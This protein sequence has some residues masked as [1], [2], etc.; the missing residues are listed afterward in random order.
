M[1]EGKYK[2][3]IVESPAKAQTIEKYLGSG[4]KVVASKGHIQDLPKKSFGVDLETFECEIVTID[5]KAETIKGIQNLAKDASEIFLASDPDREG[6]AIA[7]H[8]RNVIKRKDAHRVLFNAI[9]K[10][11]I[12]K[13]IQNPLKLDDKKYEAQQTRRILD[14]IVGYKI[15]PILWKKLQGG[16]SAGRVQS[17]ALRLVVEREEEIVNF[18][19]EKTYTLIAYL[20]KDGKVFE[21][22]YYGDNLKKKT[23]L[24]D[25]V[26]AK[27]ILE[28]IKNKEFKV[29]D[30][31]KKEKK[32][33]P[34]APFTTSKL[35][36]E[37]AYKLGFNS[38][39]TM[40][41][42][43]KLYEGINLKSHG[44]QGL[45]TYMRTDSVRS[46]PAAISAAR[47]YIENKYG[48]DYVPQDA[49]IH[50]KKKTD[51]KI[52]DAHEA[53]RPTNLD[54]D[55]ESIKT[56]LD[57]DEYLLYQLIWNKF[58]ASQMRP[59]ELDQT[60]I[61]FEVESNIFKS[62]G[63]VLKFDGFKKLYQEAQKEKQV[64]KQQEDEE[65]EDESSKELPLLNIDELLKQNK[66][67]LLQEKWTTPPAR[68]NDGT[69]IEELE[70]R[71]IGR[72]STYAAIISNIF[73]RQYVSKNKDNRY[74]PTELGAKLCKLL[75]DNFPIQMDI[76]F[77]SKMENKLDEI[78]SGDQDYK[79]LLKD[80]W[81]QLKITIDEVQ[82]NLPNIVSDEKREIPAHLKSGIK[83]LECS[84]GEYIIRKGS[85][86]DFLA[87]SRYPECKSTKNF[88]K[89]KKGLVEIVE[90]KKTYHPTESCSIC[91]SKMVIKKGTNGKFLSC[92]KYPTCKGVKP[93]PLDFICATCGEGRLVKRKSKAGKEFYGC[94]KY[95]VCS[96]VYWNK[97]VEQECSKCKHEW[98]EEITY[99]DKETKKKKVFV[100]CPKC[101]NKEAR[102]NEPPKKESKE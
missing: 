7:F 2:L 77:T 29:V 92:E 74:L 83:C 38:K 49:I 69:L 18:V 84:Q 72:P 99:K 17:V 46:E 32:Q 36:Q 9:T 28:A 90:A 20:E 79:E 51:T 50:S 53:I 94:S 89:N 52:Q 64:K 48:K 12:I 22:K 45:I 26:K 76:T 73:D 31:L 96:Q 37:A 87:C 14:R 19:P 75:V 6:E 25:E 70:K 68:F 67:P 13:A 55:P 30:V 62:S 81:G 82:K 15:S 23:N 47:T 34:T 88:K 85:N 57:R 11:E 35:Q 91:Q 4:Y 66:D 60:T 39:K 24:E 71:G 10:A 58:I 40:Q 44:R 100:Q 1:S 16:L 27:A 5:G 21:T 3:V 63:S 8:L 41:I 54:Y 97:P 33:N 42:A 98:V 93:Y 101:K 61:S 95:P 56:D 59:A 43:Q 78:E 102:K 86:G 65:E 80:F